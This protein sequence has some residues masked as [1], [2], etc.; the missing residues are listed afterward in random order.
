MTSGFREL[1]YSAFARCPCGYGLAH[2]TDSGPDGY[3]D[4]AGILLDQAD[5]NIVH[6]DRLP[7]TFW[8]VKSERQPSARGATTRP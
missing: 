7:F 2:W 8:E 1:V 3:W 4:C 6:T 5:P